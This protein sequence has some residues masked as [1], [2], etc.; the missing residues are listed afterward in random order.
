MERKNDFKAP[1]IP[2]GISTPWQNEMEPSVGPDNGSKT[3]WAHLFARLKC[4]PSHE[5]RE[6]DKH[7]EQH[8]I[9]LRRPHPSLAGQADS[10][11]IRRKGTVQGV[12][13]SYAAGI[14]WTGEGSVEIR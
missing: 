12:G 10:V 9:S 2:V 8:R 5:Q 3:L 6:N 13:L 7:F 4:G 1:K 11:A 14:P